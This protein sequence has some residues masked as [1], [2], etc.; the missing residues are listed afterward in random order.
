LVA[1]HEVLVKTRAGLVIGHEADVA[2]CVADSRAD[3]NLLAAAYIAV[4]RNFV[5]PILRLMSERDEV[6][7][8]HDQIGTP[9]W[10]TSV[11]EATKALVECHAPAGVYHWTDLGVANWYDFAMPI[12]EESLDQ[13]LITRA[14]PIVPI[15]TAEFPTRAERPAY[16]VLNCGSTRALLAIPTHHWR[17]SLR[18]MLDELQS[19]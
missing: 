16:G 12:Q 10:A 14:V 8:V 18:G 9:T 6:R 11:A 19:L 4:G 17:E 2:R 13:G 1:Q 15:S 5:L 7:V 3:W